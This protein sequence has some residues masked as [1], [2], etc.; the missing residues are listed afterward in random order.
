MKK[1]DV[2]AAMNPLNLELETLKN[3]KEELSAE[4]RLT[5]KSMDDTW[6]KIYKIRSQCE[7]SYIGKPS[8][9]MGRGICDYCGESDY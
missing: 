7:H 6:N 3:K 2:L 1:E 4:L 9:V 8:S 5:H